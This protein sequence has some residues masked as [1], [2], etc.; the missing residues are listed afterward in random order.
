MV[1]G[2]EGLLNYSKLSMT[3]NLLHRDGLFSNKMPVGWLATARSLSKSHL[4]MTA[5]TVILTPHLFHNNIS[6]MYFMYKYTLLENVQTDIGSNTIN[7]V[8]QALTTINTTMQLP[9]HLLLQQNFC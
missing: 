1:I 9:G 3:N 4:M 7:R 6:H 5:S 8:G 2:P